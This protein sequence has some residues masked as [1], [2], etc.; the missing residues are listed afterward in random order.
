[1]GRSGGFGISMPLYR[2]EVVEGVVGVG[3]VV[4]SDP[5]GQTLA[6]LPVQVWG[7][8]PSGASHQEGRG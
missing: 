2:H 5:K 7:R 3:V 6:P 1:M 4:G 8:L